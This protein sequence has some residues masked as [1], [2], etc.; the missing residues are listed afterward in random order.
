MMTDQKES[1]YWVPLMTHF[2]D[3]T[4]EDNEDVM[5]AWYKYVFYFLPIVN[6]TWRDAVSSDNLKNKRRMFPALFVSDEALVQWFIIIQLPKV[7]EDYKIGFD[8]VIKNLGT[9]KH[10]TN[11]NLEK[12]IKIHDK[13]AQRRHKWKCAVRWNHL[14]WVEVE[15][16]NSAKFTSQNESDAKP[17]ASLKKTLPLPGMNDEEDIFE[18]YKQHET[19]NDEIVP[20]VIASNVSL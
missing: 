15:K 2:Y 9:G 14:F 6:K 13:I 17:K 10:D 7:E 11:I 12:Y 16:R 1:L 5:E 8:K 3:E 19:N 18:M 20:D 4:K